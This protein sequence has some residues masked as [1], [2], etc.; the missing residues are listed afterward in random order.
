MTI[1]ND[2]S[3]EMA[4]RRRGL[5]RHAIAFVLVILMLAGIDWYTAEPYW[6]HWVV[7]GWGVGLL[8]HAM[9]ILSRAKPAHA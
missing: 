9:M 4:H 3:A 2:P 8:G 6:I 1:A 5:K 7:L